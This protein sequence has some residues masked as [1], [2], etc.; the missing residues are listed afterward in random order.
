MLY[1]KIRGGKRKTKKNK[2]GRK[3]KKHKTNLKKTKTLSKKTKPPT[4][5]SIF[6]DKSPQLQKDNEPTR[7]NKFTTKN[8]AIKNGYNTIINNRLA[9]KRPAR[10]QDL[11]IDTSIIYGP[12]VEHINKTNYK[13]IKK[14]DSIYYDRNSVVLRGPFIFQGLRRG[15]ELLFKIKDVVYPKEYL[16]TISTDK[17]DKES[18]YLVKKNTKTKKNN[19]KLKGGNKSIFKVLNGF[20]HKSRNNNWV[21]AMDSQFHI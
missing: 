20:I 11:H 19:K 8:V 4:S 6:P 9:Y 16:F 12:V 7:L 18:L 13:K 2:K 10:G 17:L 5:I 14:G 1:L 15:P 21:S 3:T